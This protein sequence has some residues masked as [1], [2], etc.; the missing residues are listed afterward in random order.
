MNEE[1][2]QKIRAAFDQIAAK[3][4]SGERT[5]PLEGQYA[6]AYQRG[7]RECG[8]PQLRKKYRSQ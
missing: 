1:K 6:A 7:V 4:R 8:W 3:M 2:C 5:A